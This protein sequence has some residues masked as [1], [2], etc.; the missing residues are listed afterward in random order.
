MR[1]NK[2]L[3]SAG[4][5]GRRK[6]EEFVVDGKV[7]VNGKIVHELSTD[8]K[9]T[10]IVSVNGKVI[11]PNNNYVYFKLHKPKGYVS[12]VS[13][14]KGRKTIMSLMRGVH[15]RVF[16]V[17]RLDYDTEGLILLTND[18]DVANILTKP[19]SE[20]EKKYIV[21]IEGNITSDEI[22]KL[23]AGVDIGDYITK[24]CSVQILDIQENS[25]RLLVTIK[26]GKNRQ[27]RRMFN[28]IG[29]T[30]TFLK[31]TDIGQIHLGGLS[32]GEYSTLNSKEIKYLKSLKR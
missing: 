24:P 2:Y 15:T 8:I 3:A 10:D 26:E 1:I 21:N 4:L 29:K 13:D 28:S 18:G 11:K 14:D 30:V 9:D 25:T 32:R 20:I 19:N 23:S 12:T 17:G 31:R 16:P 6:A 22:K 7:K 27:I 5:A